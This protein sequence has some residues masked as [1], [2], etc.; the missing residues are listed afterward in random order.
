MKNPT[1]HPHPQLGT[2]PL[3]QPLAAAHAPTPLAPVPR[4]ARHC[5]RPA[6]LGAAAPPAAT[7]T[8]HPLLPRHAGRHG[9]AVAPPG[10]QPRRHEPGTHASSP[11]PVFTGV[12]PQPPLFLPRS[13]ALTL[14]CAVHVGAGVPEDV[15]FC[16]VYGLDDEMLAMVRQPVL[17]VLLLYAQVIPES[18]RG[19]A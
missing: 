18:W 2:A 8:L 3:A 12:S 1:A 14:R 4:A 16:D 19:G 13:R 6:L 7:S 11:L 17:A 9:E 5:R 15:G 10:G